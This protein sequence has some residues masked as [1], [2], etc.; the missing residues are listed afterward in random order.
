MRYT[1]KREKHGLS[2]TRLYR[3][4]LGMRNRCNNIN[5]PAYKHYGGRGISICSEWIESFILF[6]SFSIQHGYT[7]ELTIE[8]IN[9]N[10]N[11]EPN[12][13]TFIPLNK[14]SNNCR[15]TNIITIDNITGTITDWAKIS[16]LNRGCI[17]SRWDKGKRGKELIKPKRIHKSKYPVDYISKVTGINKN[18]LYTRIKLGWK[19]EDFI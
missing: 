17:K 15:T 10:G 4:W 19:E 11:Y 14:Q 1:K 3:I 6:Y 7:D 12:N 16:G 18:A 9:V 13:V 8:R 2:N 5:V